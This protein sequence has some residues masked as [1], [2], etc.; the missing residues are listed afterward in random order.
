MLFAI[1]Q[2]TLKPISEIQSQ[3]S[4]KLLLNKPTQFFKCSKTIPFV[5][6]PALSNHH[7]GD[8]IWF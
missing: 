1:S 7:L 3:L 6:D 8:R 4:K 5:S 2:L